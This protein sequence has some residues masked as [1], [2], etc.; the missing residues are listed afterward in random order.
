MKKTLWGNTQ[1]FF[2]ISNAEMKVNLS[3]TV[4]TFYSLYEHAL[5]L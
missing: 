2:R 1:K 4:S 3:L 5:L